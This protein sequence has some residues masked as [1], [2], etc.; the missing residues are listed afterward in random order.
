[1]EWSRISSSKYCDLKL[2]RRQPLRITGLLHATQVTVGVIAIY[3]GLRAHP[4]IFN[5]VPAHPSLSREHESSVLIRK[6]DFSIEAKSHSLGLG[7]EWVGREPRR[8]QT[9]SHT[10]SIKAG[11]AQASCALL[12]SIDLGESIDLRTCSSRCFSSAA[13]KRDHVRTC[14]PCMKIDS[15]RI[16]PHNRSWAISRRGMARVE[17]EHSDRDILS[18]F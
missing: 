8:Y 13:Q 5:C 3:I 2:H 12:G 18:C 10:L 17:T 16:R 6:Q 4:S 11:R 15:R 7:L 1:M 14:L 9:I